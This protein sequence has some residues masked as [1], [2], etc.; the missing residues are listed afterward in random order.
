M[1]RIIVALCLSLLAVFG[2]NNKSSNPITSPSP[3]DTTSMNYDV[4]TTALD[5]VAAKLDSL[6][7][8]S[9]QEIA[10]KLLAF[11]RTRTEFEASGATGGT[12]VWARFSDGRLLIIPNNRELSVDTAGTLEAS[13]SELP[14]PSTPAPRSYSVPRSTLSTNYGATGQAELPRSMQ[15]QAFNS[16][17]LCHLNPLPAIKALLTAGK[18]VD[19]GGSATVTGLK[20]VKGDGIFYINAHGGQGI[21]RDSLLLMSIWT[22]NA[23]NSSDE[24][25]FAT[26]L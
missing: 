9:Q 23:R 5:A 18:Y 14:S 2:C 26:M 7:G 13:S 3:G 4:R 10:Q 24:Q 21:S 12:T 11:V 16:I 20:N 15:F 1:K 8:L 22:T 17:G 19:G 25:A 6:E